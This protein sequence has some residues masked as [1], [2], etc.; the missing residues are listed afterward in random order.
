MCISCAS[1]TFTQ[2]SSQTSRS[3]SHKTFMGYIEKQCK[4]AID[5]CAV[6]Y[7]RYVDDIFVAVRNRE[8]L[9]YLKEELE[10]I[11]RNIKFTV[12]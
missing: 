4:E 5:I 3:L 11:D 9:E 10:N 2:A 7:A 8:D 6:F 1:N 12:E